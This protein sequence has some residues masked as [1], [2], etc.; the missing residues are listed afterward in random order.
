MIAAGTAGLTRYM[1]QVT[2]T[3]AS[4]SQNGAEAKP[5]SAIAIGPWKASASSF[6][7]PCLLSSMKIAPLKKSPKS[8]GSM[9]G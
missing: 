1:Y 6:I 5:C 3:P 7:A 2:T 4:A 9:A 8:S